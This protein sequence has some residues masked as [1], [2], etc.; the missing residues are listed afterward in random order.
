MQPLNVTDRRQ[1]HKINRR[2]QP[3]NSQGRSG[4][5]LKASSGREAPLPC[6]C[7]VVG[8]DHSSCIRFCKIIPY[9]RRCCLS[10]NC[11]H[12]LSSRPK[13]PTHKNPTQ[14][15]LCGAF[16]PYLHARRSCVPHVDLCDA[17][18]RRTDAAPVLDSARH[19]YR[20]VSAAAG[21]IVMCGR[22]GRDV[23]VY[24][25]NVRWIELKRRVLDVH[26]CV[27]EHAD[28]LR[29]RSPHQPCSCVLLCATRP[30]RS[31]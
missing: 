1:S 21:S 12:R 26:R 4:V 8:R 29:R 11:T 17:E 7:L 10:S 24:R 31:T 14:T 13:N 15:Q 22:F 19:I 16:D 6:P 23:L 28:G 9:E 30:I 20:G 2:V 18:Q 25:L 27:V 5:Q 3:Y